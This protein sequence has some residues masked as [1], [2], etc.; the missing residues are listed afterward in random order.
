MVEAV[1]KV[2]SAICLLLI[3]HKLEALS[4]KKQRRPPIVLLVSS[5]VDL[6]CCDDVIIFCSSYGLRLSNLVVDPWWPTIFPACIST[7]V[8]AT[9]EPSYILMLC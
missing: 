6:E 4:L 7:I 2:A 3:F 9:L 8:P 5:S 1:S